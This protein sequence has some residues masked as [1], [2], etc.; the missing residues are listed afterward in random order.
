MKKQKF[1]RLAIDLLQKIEGE[2]MIIEYIDN[3]I[4]FH[5]S[6]HDYKE[7]M[8][9]IYMFNNTQKDT[10]ILAR[11]E[12]VKKVITGERLFCDE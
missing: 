7:G 10:E 6:H 1:K 4:W 5:H 12:Q 3:T 2:G 8:A 11:Y 9:S